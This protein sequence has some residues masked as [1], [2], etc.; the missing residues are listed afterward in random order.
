MVDLGI[1]EIKI[2]ERVYGSVK[3]PI[4]VGKE[5]EKLDYYIDFEQSGDNSYTLGVP[6][7]GG[8]IFSD[9]FYCVNNKYEAGIFDNSVC[10][11]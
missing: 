1:K 5:L 6:L 10:E 8:S 2:M 4:F 7:K 3:H 9:P 11:L